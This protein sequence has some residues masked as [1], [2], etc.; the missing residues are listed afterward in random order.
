[1]Y[2]GSVA[3]GLA[4]LTREVMLLIWSGQQFFTSIKPVGNG[5]RIKEGLG[6]AEKWLH[7][8]NV[9]CFSAIRL[10]SQ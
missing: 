10:Q 2:R 4:C 3:K 5:F 6:G 7:L 1:M 8:H 9:P